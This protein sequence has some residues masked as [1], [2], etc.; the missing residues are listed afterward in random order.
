MKA[1]PL[2]RV[3][4]NHLNKRCDNC[5]GPVAEGHPFAL[6]PK[7]LF[8]GAILVGDAGE[9]DIAERA[10]R[11]APRRDFF[12]K[13][14]LLEK[15]GGGG[16]GVVWKA[17]DFEFHRCVAMKRITEQSANDLPA[18]HRF[19]AE[20]QIASQLEHP[21]ILPIFDMGLDPDGRPYYTTQL[22]PGDTLET[23][24]RQVHA[25]GGSAWTLPQAVEMLVRVC[26]VMAHAHSRGV[27]HRDLKPANI[28][29]GAFGDVRVVDWGSAHVLKS[30]L[31]NCEA[32]SVGLESPAIETD[33]GRAMRMNPDSPLATASSGQPVT[34]LFTP[35]EI[36]AGELEALGPATD[37]YALG[38]MLYQLLT[39]RLPYGTPDGKFPEKEELKQRILCGSPVPVRALNPRASR[40]LAAICQQAMAHRQADRYSAMSG[41][42]EDLRA[43]LEIRPVQARRPGVFL[44][45]QK[46]SQRN[47][48]YVLLAG[49]ALLL[50]A[51]AFSSAHGFKAQRDAARQST[52]VRNAELAARNG[53]WRDA[54]QN[55]QAADAAGY[56]DKIY[57]GLQVAEAWTILSEPQKSQAEL[58]KLSRRGDLGAQRGAVLLRLG[59][60]ELFDAAT[61]NQGVEHIRRALACGLDAADVLF[62]KGLLAETTPEALDRFHQALQI[63]SFH[64]GAHR[65]SLGLEFLLGRH[66][67]LQA[68]SR[69]F[70]AIYPDDPSA[71]YLLAAELAMQGRLDEAR[72]K[73]ASLKPSTATEAWTRMNERLPLL[74]TAAKRFDPEVWLTITRSALPRLDMLASIEPASEMGG[75][76]TNGPVASRLPFLPC[77]QQGL[78]EGRAAISS[79]ML[80]FVANIDLATVRIKKAWQHHPEAL[81]PAFAGI[82]L[83]QRQPTNGVKSRHVLERQAEL[84]QLAADSPSLLAGLDRTARFLAVKTEFELLQTNPTNAAVLRQLCLGNLQQALSNPAT[85]SAECKAYYELAMKLGEYDLA[86]EMIFQMEQRQ[87]GDPATKQARLELELATGNLSAAWRLDNQILTASPHDERALADRK[88]IHRML[89]EFDGLIKTENQST[90]VPKLP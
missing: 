14:D 26:E 2:V 56:G 42:A 12:E 4:A 36:V 11:P 58:I 65:H 90:E 27:I 10:F 7:C 75:G 40:D 13:Y 53:H 15:V 82:Y 70:A 31:V 5:G 77:V 19:Q 76:S 33:R 54:L 50:L 9:T 68:S 48:S 55:W 85:S 6:C 30:S 37:I 17:W 81:V 66:A 46:W 1:A 34:L 84:F 61:A 43:A 59:E 60:H 39:G 57:L 78:L 3:A 51:V 18:I 25:A 16:Q 32:S 73:L 62:A 74:A 87:P 83:E 45:L 24:W 22:L 79:L 89:D 69:F 80:P 41:L 71:G 23:V 88:T 47:F 35:P 20:A 72:A 44:K 64:H 21:G 29:V 52:L 49:G 86:R 8:G 38:V 28:L 67:D 63:N